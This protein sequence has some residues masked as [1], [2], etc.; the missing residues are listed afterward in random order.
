MELMGS[1][2]WKVKRRGYERVSVGS[3]RVSMERFGESD[4]EGKAAL[5]SG[6]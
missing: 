3:E 4:I 1:A 5:G 6:E 2:T